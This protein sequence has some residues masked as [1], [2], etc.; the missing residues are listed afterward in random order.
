LQFELEEKLIRI[1]SQ[2]GIPRKGMD[3]IMSLMRDQEVIASYYSTAKRP[4]TCFKTLRLRSMELL[5]C[6]V[7]C[8]FAVRNISTKEVVEVFDK[9]S[10]AVSKFPK[11]SYKY[12]YEGAFCKVLQ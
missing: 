2:Y 8:F 10:I 5:Q 3:E 11:D 9:D 1:Q 4:A 6:P 12:L 7:R